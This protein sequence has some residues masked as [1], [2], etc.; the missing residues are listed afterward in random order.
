MLLMKGRYLSLKQWNIFCCHYFFFWPQNDWTSTFCL[1]FTFFFV[2]VSFYYFIL[3]YFLLLF[4]NN[5]WCPNSFL[6]YKLSF[7]AINLYSSW[8][9][10]SKLSI[11]K[12]MFLVPRACGNPISF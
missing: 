9:R 4:Q 1:I 5:N 3:F 8:P 11:R 10:E 6:M 2:L 12:Q 7:V